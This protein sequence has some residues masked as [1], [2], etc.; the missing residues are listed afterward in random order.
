M[1]AAT[2]S[3]VVVCDRLLRFD[4]RMRKLQYHLRCLNQDLTLM[5]QGWNLTY[6]LDWC[7][8]YRYAFGIRHVLESN[9]VPTLT[10]RQRHVFVDK[11][12]AIRLLLSG[13]HPN[14]RVL[15]LP[16]YAYE[17]TI[18]LER[19][20]GQGNRLETQLRRL[21]KARQEDLELK[22]SLANIR[23]WH[24]KHPDVPVPQHLA[25]AVYR[26]LRRDFKSILYELLAISSRGVNGLADLLGG[27]GKRI[28][29]IDELWPDLIDSIRSIREDIVV[30]SEWFMRFQEVR[31]RWLSDF[32]DACAVM[33]VERLNR[34]LW[35]K[36]ECLLLVS[37]AAT[38]SEVLNWDL[39]FA[40][41]H[42]SEDRPKGILDW[43]SLESL[44][45]GEYRLLRTPR[46]FL[47]YMV[48]GGQRRTAAR[49]IQTS[50]FLLTQYFSLASRIVSHIKT[51]C[52]NYVR[53]DRRMVKD[54]E[55]KCT[56][57]PYAGD[58]QS[59]SNLLKRYEG[60]E[61]EYE[62]VQLISR[63]P[64]VLTASAVWTE[65]TIGHLL[66][67]E[68]SRELVRMAKDA[69]G[70]GSTLGGVLR[71]RRGELESR[72]S[73]L[74]GSVAVRAL[75]GAPAQDIDILG[76][77]VE[78]FVRVFG[79]LGFRSEVVG[80]SVNGMLLMLR[81]DEID[82]EKTRNA[83]LELHTIAE[84]ESLT[85]SEGLLL[86]AALAYVCEERKYCWHLCEAEIASK[87][88]QAEFGIRYLRVLAETSVALREEDRSLARAAV[89]H[90]RVLVEEAGEEARS[91]HV[92]GLVSAR[93]R[94]A[95]LV[96]IPV[97]EV[98][99][100][101]RE[102]CRRCND[103]ELRTTIANNLLYGICAL[104]E[105]HEVLRAEVES[106]LELLVSF[107]RSQMQWSSYL[108]TEAA[109]CLWLLELEKNKEEREVLIKQAR[110]AEMRALKLAR[111]RGAGPEEL[112]Q[113]ESRMSEIEKIKRSEEGERD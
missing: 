32:D 84:D 42:D 104:C 83:I 5:D 90:A 29:Y 24:L 69:E 58:S 87:G 1:Q 57:C 25:R 26:T 33:M 68:L 102:A 88:V 96:D 91:W 39:S 10:T 98:C 52:P 63:G 12:A 4:T 67:E 64:D 78:K 8:L 20:R 6:A 40:E 36:R 71:D 97:G 76:Y 86:S 18:F 48:Y 38:M 94:S 81:G 21:A 62:V 2:S 11:A 72:L 22:R 100:R 31:G 75:V 54:E 105:P 43:R 101:L 110:S 93:L 9:E 44:R 7:E 112:S 13:F 46:T 89:E 66:G 34:Q 19:L 80:S 51:R 30:Q 74:R 17:M 15:L 85:G 61:R 47:I 109:A 28:L 53:E 113:F 65:E 55:G 108:D 82:T 50:L 92:Y 49:R 27:S 3:P 70:E 77:N 60:L 23:D 79:R 14:A 45:F 73:D 103:P 95:D 106:L 37:D 35:K 59:I 99:K 56:N 111:R 16:P 107:S 41:K